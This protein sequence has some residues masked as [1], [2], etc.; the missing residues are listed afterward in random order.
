MNLSNTQLYILK[1]I[2]NN[3]NL[4][5]NTSSNIQ[6]KIFYI[7]PGLGESSTLQNYKDLALKLKKLNFEV[8]IV[9]IKWNN[10]SL[11]DYINDFESQFIHSEKDLIYILGFS[12]GAIILI[13][14]KI[15]MHQN[16]KKIYLCSPSPIFKEDSKHY[17]IIMKLLLFFY[18]PKKMKRELKSLSF[19]NVNLSCETTIFYGSKERKELIKGIDKFKDKFKL[20][21]II[22][23]EEIGHEFSNEKYQK[24]VLMKIS[25]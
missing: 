1:Y 6:K 2:L 3:M 13:L 5:F 4:S 21:K 10:Y 24:A 23:I 20:L 18:I 15:T 7:I 11:N 16:L 25:K 19:K 8:K 14:S 22:Y 12:I 17:S 9:N